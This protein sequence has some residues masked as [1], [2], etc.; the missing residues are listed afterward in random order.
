M[1]PLLDPSFEVTFRPSK[2]LFQQVRPLEYGIRVDRRESNMLEFR[3]AA[4]NELRI[5]I[6]RPDQEVMAAIIDSR[7]E[8]LTSYFKVAGT[9]S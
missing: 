2:S 7:I 5:H 3:D 9:V 6:G 8:T 1:N 4:V